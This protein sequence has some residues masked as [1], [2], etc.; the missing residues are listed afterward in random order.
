MAMW[1]GRC[2]LLAGDRERVSEWE[3]GRLLAHRVILLGFLKMVLKFS[4]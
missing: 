2:L 4:R 3:R 1:Y